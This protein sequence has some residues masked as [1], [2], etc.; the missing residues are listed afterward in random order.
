[1]QTSYLDDIDGS[2]RIPLIRDHLFEELPRERFKAARMFKHY[3]SVDTDFVDIDVLD[4]VFS[5]LSDPSSKVRDAAKQALVA[6]ERHEKENRSLWR[7]R[8]N[9]RDD[10]VN[11]TYKNYGVEIA[12]GKFTLAD[13]KAADAHLYAALKRAEGRGHLSNR[14]SGSQDFQGKTTKELFEIKPG[15]FGFK[16]DLLELVRR[17]RR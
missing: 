2:E 17:L 13:L 9:R 3:M 5:R 4:D 14:L 11:F 16:I 10:P 6:A 15:A 8:D 1:M 7:D 12:L